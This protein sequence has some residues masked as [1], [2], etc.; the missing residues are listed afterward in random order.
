MTHDMSKHMVT[1]ERKNWKERK[2]KTTE[3][4][5]KTNYNNEITSLVHIVS[6]IMIY[7]FL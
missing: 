3:R 4:Q 6:L 7:C 5:K 2:E 1:V